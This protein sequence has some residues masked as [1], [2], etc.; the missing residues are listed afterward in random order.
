MHVNDAIGT[1]QNVT[2]QANRRYRRN[3]YKRIQPYRT[4]LQELSGP[5]RIKL[6]KFVSEKI[7]YFY[8]KLLFSGQIFSAPPSKML[9]RT[10]M[11]TVMLGVRLPDVLERQELSL[12]LLSKLVL[13]LILEKLIVVL[14][15]FPATLKILE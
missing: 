1:E 13:S 15:Y 9:S 2:L 14:E 8:G 7:V 11:L 12:N 4:D 5:I 10:S 3:C 6:K